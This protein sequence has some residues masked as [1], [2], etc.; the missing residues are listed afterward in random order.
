MLKIKPD[1]IADHSKQP[2]RQ[3]SA[4]NIMATCFQRH[5]NVSKQR[6]NEGIGIVGPPTLCVFEHGLNR[7]VHKGT[8]T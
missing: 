6:L 2:K 8:K 1:S 3:I 7:S 4:I 5:A